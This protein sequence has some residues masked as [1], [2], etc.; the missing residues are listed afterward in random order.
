MN[1]QTTHP[2]RIK[3]F[4]S[5]K[6]KVVHAAAIDK[7]LKRGGTI[8]MLPQ[9]DQDDLNILLSDGKHDAL[10][11]KT[12]LLIRELLCKQKA[13]SQVNLPQGPGAGHATQY[14][15]LITYEKRGRGVLIKC[16][17][18]HQEMLVPTWKHSG[19]SW[20][21]TNEVHIRRCLCLPGDTSA[22]LHHAC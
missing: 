22:H 6:C 5:D 3:Q 8:S 21:S 9:A 11:L 15:P 16:T 18:A 13:C 2:C 7:K 1:T 14:P 20:R 19:S 17:R 12:C 10:S 4:L